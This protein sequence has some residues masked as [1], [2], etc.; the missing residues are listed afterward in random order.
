MK[1]RQLLAMLVLAGTGWMLPSPSALAGLPQPMCIYYGQARDGYGM[2][3]MQ[4]ADVILR[5]GATEIVRHTIRGS[6]SPGVNFALA[7]HLDD[8]QSAQSYSTRALRSGDRISI[9]V[10]DGEGEKT[11]MEQQ[12]VPAVGIPGELIL[13]HVTA[14][15]DADGDGLSDT[16]EKE[17]IAWSDGRFQGLQDV[18]GADDFDG[19]GVSNWLEYQ[20]GTFAFLDNDYCYVEQAVPTSNGRLRLGFVSTAGKAYSVQSATSLAANEWA[21]CPFGVAD[22]DPLQV[23]P[24]EGNG[25]WISVYVPLGGP[26]HFFRLLVE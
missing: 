23:T 9:V 4:G 5:R 13:R 7:V 26:T 18:H 14:A 24:V 1:S 3:Y 17:L 16:W 20:A 2:P 19:D 12:V 6:L 22:T 15:E 11:I 8:G 10:R 25:D 21:S